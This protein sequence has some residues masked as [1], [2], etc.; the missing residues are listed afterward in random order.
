MGEVQH[1]RFAFLI[2]T[3]KSPAIDLSSEGSDPPEANLKRLYTK[4]CTHSPVDHA[5]DIMPLADQG[6]DR[7]RNFDTRLAVDAVA[8]SGKFSLAS[9]SQETKSGRPLLLVKNRQ[10]EIVVCVSKDQK[11]AA[12]LIKASVL[13]TDGDSGAYR[14]HVFVLRKS[15]FF[16][17]RF[18]NMTGNIAANQITNCIDRVVCDRVIH[19]I[20]P[21]LTY[22]QPV[23]V[24]HRQVPRYIRRGT[25]AC[26]SQLSNIML[27]S[28]Q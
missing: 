18:G 3:V 5:K 13:A 7:N 20:T 16:A 15:R 21:A 19:G 1:L 14:A 6:L 26:V 4:I 25:A 8:V 28:T 27:F 24:K 10:R 23:M 11:Q 2:R 9:L 12:A 22:Y 17:K